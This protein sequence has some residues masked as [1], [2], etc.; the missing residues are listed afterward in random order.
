MV[1]GL[2]EGIIQKDDLSELQK[3]ITNTQ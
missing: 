2:I 1:A 3:C